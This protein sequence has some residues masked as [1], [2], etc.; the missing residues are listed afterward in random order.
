VDCQILFFDSNLKWY[1]IQCGPWKGNKLQ[2]GPLQWI[3]IQS[4]PSDTI[5]KFQPEMIFYSMWTLKRKQTTKWTTQM[6]FCTKWTAKYYFL[7]PTWNDILFNVDPEKEINYKV[8]H[9]NE[10]QYKVD[11]QILFFNSNL[12]WYFIQ[13]GP[14]KGN[15]LQR[16]PL[17]LI[18]VQ[19]GPSNI[20]KF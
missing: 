11:R 10:F 8:D 2:C 4:G 13:C 1:F 19:S 6:N 18:S 16:W 5:F 9:S 7:I 14:W 3:S 12:K 20:L 17:Q 15:K